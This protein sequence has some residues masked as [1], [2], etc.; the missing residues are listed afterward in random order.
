VSDIRTFAEGNEKMLLHPRGL[1][2]HAINASADKPHAFTQVVWGEDVDFLKPEQLSAILKN[3]KAGDGENDATLA[4]IAK[5]ASMVAHKRPSAKFLEVA[6][7]DGVA[8]GRSLWIDLLRE[9]AGPIAEGCAYTISVSSQAAG[10]QAREAYSAEGNIEYVVHDADAPFGGENKYDVVIL[11]ASHIT[12]DMN[13]VLESARGA[14]AE[15]GYVTVLH[16]SDL[17]SQYGLFSLYCFLIETSLTFTKV[18]NVSQLQ[19]V[20]S[21]RR[22]LKIFRESRPQGPLVLLTLVLREQKKQAHFHPTPRS[23]LCIS[24]HLMAPS[25]GDCGPCPPIRQRPRKEHCDSCG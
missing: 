22:D 20:M 7:D 16:D 8:V 17:S 6:L 12:A 10:L 15:N 1:R 14:L 25:V 2:Y 13:S 18:P 4:R 3:V 23:T 9:R 21:L 5:L 19:S 11:K 24:A